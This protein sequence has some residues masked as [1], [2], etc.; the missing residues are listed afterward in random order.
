MDERG[1][2]AE[3]VESAINTGD[4]QPARG[5]RFLFKI[6]IPF[7]KT[8]SKKEYQWKQI[9]P[10]VAEEEDRIVVITVLTFYF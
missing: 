2:S 8:W 5:G 6:T 9:A 1:A 3:E 10:I 7:N 4:R